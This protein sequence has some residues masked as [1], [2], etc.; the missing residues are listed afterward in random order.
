[1]EFFKI[2]IKLYVHYSFF[3]SFIDDKTICNG[4]IESIRYSYED[5]GQGKKDIIHVKLESEIRENYTDKKD[6]G[7]GLTE[8]FL[9]KARIRLIT[10]SC[11]S[12]DGGFAQYEIL[13]LGESI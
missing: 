6:L 12:G 7:H 9:R 8:A 1:M 10:A 4:R 11:R 13:D 2:C 5:M 3:Y